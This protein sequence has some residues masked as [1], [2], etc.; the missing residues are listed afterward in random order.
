LLFSESA[1][2]P[3]VHGVGPSQMEQFWTV[4]L[5]LHFAALP[6]FPDCYDK[7]HCDNTSTLQC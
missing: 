2:T 7:L 3:I 4:H 1:W 6:S 5:L